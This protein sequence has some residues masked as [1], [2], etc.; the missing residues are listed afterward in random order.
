MDTYFNIK[1]SLPAEPAGPII[2]VGDLT[3]TGY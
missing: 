2:N 1:I 3:F